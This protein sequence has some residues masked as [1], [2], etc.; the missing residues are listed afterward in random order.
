MKSP[1]YIIARVFL[2]AYVPGH[3]MSPYWSG[4]IVIRNNL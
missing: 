2:D 3:Y 1:G 4:Y